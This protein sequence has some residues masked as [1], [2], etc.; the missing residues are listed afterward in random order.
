MRTGIV[1]GPWAILVLMTAGVVTPAAEPFKD[2]SH[3]PAISGLFSQTERGE[4]PPLCATSSALDRYLEGLYRF[5]KAQP[6]TGLA[7]DGATSPVRLQDGIWIVEADETSLIHD[8]PQDMEG[9]SLRYVPNGS[10]YAV[11]IESQQYDPDIG[12][13]RYENISDR[14]YADVVLT[15]FAF[16]LGASSWSEL[17]IGTDLSVRT[18]TPL[19]APVFAFDQYT[20]PSAVA[21]LFTDTVDRLSPLYFAK[22]GNLGRYLYVKD[23]SEK[24]LLTWRT[25][26]DPATEIFYVD[27]QAALFPDGQILYSYQT[28]KNVDNGAPQVY[29]GIADW[30]A[31]FVPTTSG[32]DPVDA[33]PPAAD[34]VAVSVEEDPVSDVVHVRVTMADTIPPA[35]AQKIDYML[36]LS[37][38]GQPV[39]RFLTWVDADGRDILYRFVESVGGTFI[40]EAPVTIN[41]ANWD[42]MF[43]LSDFPDLSSG[44][45]EITAETEVDEI[46]ADTAV[47]STSITGG[48]AFA[49]DYTGQAPFSSAI[50]IVESFLYPWFVTHGIKDK[51]LAHTGWD[52]TQIDGMPMYQTFFTDLILWAGAYYTYGNCE[53]ANIGRCD[54]AESL[55]PGLLHMNKTNF[56]HWNNASSPVRFTVL[57]HEFGHRWLQLVD[58]DEGSGP[59]NVLNPISAHPAAYVHLEAVENLVTPF[60]SSVMGG[61]Y[62]TDN[63]NGTWSTQATDTY[64]SYSATDLYLMGLMDPSEVFDWF[65]LDNTIPAQPQAYWPSPNTIAYGEYRNVTIQML[66]DAMGPREPAYPNSKSDLFTPMILVVRPGEEPS[67]SDWAFMMSVRD[68]W[69]ESFNIQTH[70]R[71]TVTTISPREVSPSGTTPLRIEKLAGDTLRL[72]FEDPAFDDQVKYNLYEGSLGGTFD[73]W[74]SSIC[75]AIPGQSAGGELYLDRAPPLPGESYY[76]LVTMSNVAYE[77]DAGTGSTGETRTTTGARCGVQ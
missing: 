3:L 27:V 20:I 1:F 34:I 24:L 60:D 14:A 12:P 48:A 71:G 39:Y 63:G 22:G 29:A 56:G 31:G 44:S 36:T 67:A 41:G 62:W 10:G 52:E 61:A 17:W 59:S 72:S 11:S 38:Q 37:Q 77:G 54:P 5:A 19:G 13:S 9:L 69:R 26:L 76:Y 74:D 30:V 46:L 28:L 64:F 51:L 21:D 40:R 33:S 49:R 32:T 2:R 53:A 70:G 18:Q 55:K 35:S 6:P 75:N 42:V 15:N 43:S 45:I 4:D 47:V 50:P 16:P 7:V 58:I 23:T 66:I 25:A 8:N 68:P 57:G 65:Y 73:D